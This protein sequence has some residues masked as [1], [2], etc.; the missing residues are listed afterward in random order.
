MES[1]NWHQ[2]FG[3]LAHG[4]SVKEL[5][6]SSDIMFVRSQDG[7]AVWSEEA[8]GIVFTAKRT[9]ELFGEECFPEI[10]ENLSYIINKTTKEPSESFKRQREFLN[11]SYFTLSYISD[12]P[13][14]MIKKIEDPGYRTPVKYL[15]R[16]AIALSI[17]NHD[18][19]KRMKL[20]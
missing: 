18:F 5:A 7:L 10:W 16:V 2:I 14:S 1:K 13:I 6:E 3:H 20:E 8:T 4:D 19:A 12:I 17:N 15:L 11:Y 9:F